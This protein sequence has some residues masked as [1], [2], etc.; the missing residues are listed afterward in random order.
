MTRLFTNAGL[1]TL[2]ALL[3]PLL[4]L[5][6]VPVL[7]LPLSTTTAVERWAPPL[8]RPLEVS[9][10][11]R[12]PPHQYA[13][14]HRGIDINAVPGEAVLAPVSGTVS[15]AGT[16]AD[17]GTVSIQTGERTVVS[18]E[19]VTAEVVA[20]EEVRRGA[21]IG[22]VS[23]GGHCST[24]CVHVGVRVGGAYVNPMRYFANR[25]VLLPW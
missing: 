3:M 24:E 17:R 20:G 10:P 12:A 13:S 23:S 1:A 16:V 14:G 15:F 22:A 4:V 9:G 6:L 8:G 11:F 7:M 18:L 25:P 5:V 2:L 21:R 19:P